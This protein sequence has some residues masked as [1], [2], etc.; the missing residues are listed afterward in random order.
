MVCG[1]THGLALH[2]REGDLEG[3]FPRQGL[4]GLSR[5]ADIGRVSVIDSVNVLDQ[6]SRDSQR[7][8]NIDGGQVRASAA[9]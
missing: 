5:I 7:L 2:Y 6:A 1:V 3:F 8:G 9:Q 4:I